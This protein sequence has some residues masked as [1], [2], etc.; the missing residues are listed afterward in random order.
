MH[1][2]GVMILLVECDVNGEVRVMLVLPC[3]EAYHTIFVRAGVEQAL[4]KILSFL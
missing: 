2:F 3:C 1:F 4:T